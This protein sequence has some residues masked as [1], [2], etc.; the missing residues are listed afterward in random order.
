MKASEVMQ[1][2][3]G[4]GESLAL[5]FAS[6]A[7]ADVVTY[8]VLHPDGTP[9]FRAL[10]R[11]T[12]VSS[13]SL[14]HELARLQRLGMIE[15]MEEG[16]LV[17]YRATAGHPRWSLFRSILREFGEPVHILRMAVS[18]VPGVEAAF[19]FGSCARGEMRPESDIDVFALGD[20]LNELQTRLDLTQ[21]TMEAAMVLNR[22]VNV[23]RYTQDKF[24]ARRE[25]GFL[26][27][28][29]AGPKQWLVG[30]ET[31]LS[32]AGA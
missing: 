3:L 9:H 10:Q 4:P 28:V 6:R 17:R 25:G 1:Q 21:G 26:S 11:I 15:R 2:P 22:E 19:I 5:V 13:R 16:R 32:P 27:A 8:F 14:Q 20:G 24:E 7:M 12:G 31:L 30:D 23:V 29:L 18:A